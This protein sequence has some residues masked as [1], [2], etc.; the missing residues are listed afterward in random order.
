LQLVSIVRL[1]I[2][3]SLGFVLWVSRLNKSGRGGLLHS[4]QI[5]TRENRLRRDLDVTSHL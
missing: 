2:E 3:K 5:E 4:V 1:T